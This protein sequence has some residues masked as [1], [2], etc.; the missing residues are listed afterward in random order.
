MCI[1][2]DRK[3]GRRAF[4]RLGGALSMAALLGDAAFAAG[5][6]ATSLTADQALAKL[7]EG[8]QRY[9]SSPQAC[10][11]DLA[12]ARA[13]VAQHQAP[14]ATILSCADSRV[15]PE[16]V[17]GGQNVGELFVARNAGNMADIATLGTIEY[18]AAALGVPLIVV[19]GHAR[20]GAVASACEVVEKN[21]KFPGSIG[22][23]LEPIIPAA[24]A[25][26][27]EPGDFVDNAV[28][29]NAKRTAAKIVSSSKIVADLVATGKVKVVAARYDLEKGEVNFFS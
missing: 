3:I 2:C 19:L 5:G 23:M 12:K 9:V 29:E 16:L 6:K 18:G 14:W 8:N 1:V 21:S 11:V 13:N 15:P 24:L 4:L 26:K 17:F 20:C 27:G 28:R 10:A 22:P 7:K 25:V